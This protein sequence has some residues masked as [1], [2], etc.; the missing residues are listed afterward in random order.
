VL[1]SSQIPWPQL[2]SAGANFLFRY[3][4]VSTKLL[5]ISHTVF[6]LL[7]L[8]FSFCFV[9]N[10]AKFS[11]AF[12]ELALSS[13]SFFAG[14]GLIAKAVDFSAR[15]LGCFAFGTLAE[16]VGGGSVSETAPD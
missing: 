14:C 3:G 12:D 8:G 15:H 7:R 5:G 6:S 1:D 16:L 2:R 11:R 10:I 9:T 13:C 4:A